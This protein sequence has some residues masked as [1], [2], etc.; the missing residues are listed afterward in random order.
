MME[1]RMSSEE[2]NMSE[3]EFLQV[4]W[5]QQ[6]ILSDYILCKVKNGYNNCKLNKALSVLLS[7]EGV[8]KNMYFDQWKSNT[9][10]FRIK[11]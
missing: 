8:I 7:K 9:C 1:Q 2:Y 10:K 3:A 11:T 4:K 6:Q 5:Q